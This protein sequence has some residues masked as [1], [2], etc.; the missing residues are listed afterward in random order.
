[1]PSSERFSRE[2][3]GWD[4]P[5]AKLSWRPVSCTLHRSEGENNGEDYNAYDV[6][7]AGHT[8]QGMVI[9]ALQVLMWERWHRG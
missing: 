6:K 9:C 7:A 5:L 3:E 2:G 8:S 1:M 4:N